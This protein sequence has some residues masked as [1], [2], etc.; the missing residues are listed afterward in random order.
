MK[1]FDDE[2]VRVVQRLSE[3]SPISRIG[4]KSDIQAILGDSL[5]NIVDTHNTNSIL[6]IFTIDN[7]KYLCKAELGK[8]GNTVTSEIEWYK[9]T[10]SSFQYS[11]TLLFSISNSI[12][13]AEILSFIEKS[14]TIDIMSTS[15]NLTENISPYIC[16]AFDY[17][18]QLFNAFKRNHLTK[19]ASL[20]IITSKFSKRT[21]ESLKVSFLNYLLNLPEVVINGKNYKNISYFINKIQNEQTLQSLLIPEKYGIIHGDLHCGNILINDKEEIFFIDPNGNMSLPLE[22]DI[23]KLFHSVH[24]GYGLIMDGRYSLEV[25][26]GNFEFSVT[27]PKHYSEAFKQIRRSIDDSTFY[28]SLFME[29]M[30]FTTM[31]PHHAKREKET[32]ALFLTAVLLYSELFSYLG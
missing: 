14:S 8:H 16:K 25:N 21:N 22:Y 5:I 24:G 4:L 20:S 29:S 15:P 23:G 30:H 9:K 19:K 11:P 31:L 27:I 10:R 26:G 1:R 2:F 18:N 13:S 12:F 28:R 17:N 6:F 7:K 32:T 3:I